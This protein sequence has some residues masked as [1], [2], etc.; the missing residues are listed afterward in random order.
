MEVFFFCSIVFFILVFISLCAHQY[1]Y[2]DQKLTSKYNPI[3]HFFNYVGGPSAGK[4]T[5]PYL[6]F[7]YL[8]I[9]L[10]FMIVFIV[11]TYQVFQH[12]RYSSIGPIIFY[13]TLF[14]SIILLF[15]V[16]KDISFFK[17]TKKKASFHFNDTFF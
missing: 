5:N 2:D 16:F 3:F 7:F 9:L 6:Y 14:I 4:K 11:N 10:I 15:M 1:L 12:S 8:A 13:C 17:D